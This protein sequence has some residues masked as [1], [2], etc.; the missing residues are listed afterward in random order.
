[1][2]PNTPIPAAQYLRMSTDHQQYS[3]RSQ[4]TAIQNML[5]FTASHLSRLTKMPGRV[6]CR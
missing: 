6:A 2:N 3:L 4:T 1:M 5:K